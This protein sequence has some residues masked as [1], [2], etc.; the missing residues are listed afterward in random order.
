M[1]ACYKELYQHLDVLAQDCLPSCIF[2]HI[3]VKMSGNWQ[4][5]HD[6]TNYACMSVA[7]PVFATDKYCLYIHR[8]TQ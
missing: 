4:K 6:V 1:N 5:R 3:P 2:Q 7:E 8:I